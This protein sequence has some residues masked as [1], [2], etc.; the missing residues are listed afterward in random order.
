MQLQDKIVAVTGATRGLGLAIVRAFAAEGASVA[1][2]ARNSV[3]LLRVAKEV[4]GSLPIVCDVSNPADVRAGFARIAAE[5]DGLD[6]LVNNAA[7]G[8]PQLIEESSDDLLRLEVEVNLLGP[9]YCMREAIPLLRAR[10]SGDIINV[11]SEAVNNPYPFLGLYA[12]TKSA[13]ETLS[14]AV[15]AEV[16][17]SGI[18]VAVYRSAR[19]IGG[20]FSRDWDPQVTERARTAAAATGFYERS[21]K[22]IPAEVAANNIL[23]W[24][25]SDRST[26][27]DLIEPDGD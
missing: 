1:M 26:R 27:I 14:A 22:A 4:S 24:V 17:D 25:L 15:R 9:L 12:A 21:G 3:D 20:T 8:N 16:G 11:S 23:Q 18:R 13:L 2:L 6:V 10:G 19:V 5:F 7:V